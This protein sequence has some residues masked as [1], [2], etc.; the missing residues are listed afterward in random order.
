MRILFLSQ[1]YPP[2]PG[3]PAARISEL[4]R[5]WALRG[6][7][8]TVLTGFPN[9]PSGVIPEEY[10]GAILR[11]ERDLGV[12]VLRTF[13]YA[14]ANRGKLR[15][16]AAYLSYAASAA[17]LGQFF[18]GKPDVLIATSPQLLCG[19]AG[20][21]VA[22]WKRVPFVL[23]VRD[24]WPESIVAVGALAAGH[25]V[26]RGLTVLEE[27]LY[28]RAAHIVLVT[29]SFRESLLR[30]GIADKKLSVVKNG[31]DLARFTPLSRDT[32]LRRELGAEDRIVVGYVGTHGMAHGLDTVLDVAKG[33]PERLFLFV[34]DGAERPRLEE[35]A[36]SEK[37]ENVRF[38]GMLPRERMPEIYATCDL[39]I[40]PLRKTE[41]FTTVIPSKMF[42]IFA[43]ERPLVLSVDGEAREIG[44]ASGGAIF[45]PPEDRDAMLANVERLAGDAELRAQMG[46]RARAFVL[47]EFDRSALADRYLELLGPIAERA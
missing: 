20:A 41:L 15:R 31:V 43:M 9:H 42:E 34:G 24:L 12:T 6:H 4:A 30:R 35:R 2:E 7:D 28:R 22:A 32:D 10:R 16:S 25:P 47:A 23:E 38:L 46:K 37:I 39:L 21:L 1:Y 36:R 5:A 27:A 13:I 19:A 33:L 3:A 11:R 18:T 14:A 8:V 40:V 26:I 29:D 44:E 45:S 17:L